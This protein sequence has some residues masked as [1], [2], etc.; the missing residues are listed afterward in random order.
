[1]LVT[2]AIHVQVYEPMV[3]IYV[4]LEVGKGNVISTSK[5]SYLSVKNDRGNLCYIPVHSIARKCTEH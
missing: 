1:M 2:I 3:I 5:N 4:I